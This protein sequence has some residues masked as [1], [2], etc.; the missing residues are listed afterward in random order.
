MTL[1]TLQQHGGYSLVAFHQLHQLTEALGVDLQQPANRP[2]LQSIMTELVS[3]VSE[4]ATGLVL[5]PDIGLPELVHK[6]SEAGVLLPLQINTDEMDPLAVP[7]LD[8]Q[9]GLEQIANNYAVAYLELFYHPAESQAL[10]KKQ[11]VAELMD[12]CQYLSIHLVVRLRVF[13]PHGEML[14]PDAFEAARIQS[15]QELQPVCHMLVLDTPDSVLSAATLT[16]ELDIPWIVWLEAPKYEQVKDGLR[17]SVE[18]GAKGFMIGSS[19][20][21]ELSSFRRRDAGVD[22]SAI[23][24]YIKTTV[25]DRVIELSRIVTEEVV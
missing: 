15:I 8:S 11:M 6:K 20:W 18:S 16:A 17:L 3:V 24:T 1:P 4:P 9:W 12:Y 25:R 23:K 22:E 5:H 7:V 13:S 19:L 10:L 21:P 2:L 14:E